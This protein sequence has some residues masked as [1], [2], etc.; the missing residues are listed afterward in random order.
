M[1]LEKKRTTF[2]QKTFPYSDK[3]NKNDVRNSDPDNFLMQQ[4]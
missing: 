2:P 3:A 1:E 4:H